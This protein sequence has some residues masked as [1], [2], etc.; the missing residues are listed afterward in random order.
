M[1]TRSILGGLLIA[2]LLGLPAARADTPVKVQNE[3]SFLLGYVTGSGCEFYRNGDW[4]N[5]RKAVAHLRDKY[6][7]LNDRNLVS[8]TEQFIERAASESSFSGKPYQ[9]RCSGGAAV[10]SQQWLSEKLVELRAAQ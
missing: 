1:H 6:K 2:A 10:T 5:A 7:Y 9:I 3:V 8:T 4:Y